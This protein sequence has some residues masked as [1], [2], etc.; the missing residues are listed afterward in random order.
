MGL[1]SSED[2]GP[3]HFLE[4]YYE[5]LDVVYKRSLGGWMRG[6]KE[7]KAGTRVQVY[8]CLLGVEF[9]RQDF[10]AW[11]M[12]ISSAANIEWWGPSFHDWHRDKSSRNA[13]AVAVGACL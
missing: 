13:A 2:E 10:F 9:R 12:A 7:E 4:G 3:S 1:D 11:H 5:G 8:Y 6:E